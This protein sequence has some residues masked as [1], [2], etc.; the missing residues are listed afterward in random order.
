MTSSLRWN[1][2]DLESLTDDTKRYEIIDGELY[3][4]RLPHYYHQ[5]VC[6]DLTTLLDVWSK[7]RPWAKSPLLP[8]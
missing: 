6:V 5:R 8:V 2:R 3:V 7:K 1:S 4:S